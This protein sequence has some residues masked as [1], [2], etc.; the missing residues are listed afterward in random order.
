MRNGAAQVNNIMVATGFDRATV[1]AS[2]KALEAAGY[3][4][5]VEGSRNRFRLRIRGADS[6]APSAVSERSDAGRTNEIEAR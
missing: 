4:E 1:L 3:L 2:I 5:A 6:V